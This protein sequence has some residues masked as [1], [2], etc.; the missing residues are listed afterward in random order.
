MVTPRYA[1]SQM[2]PALHKRSSCHR[3]V[4]KRGARLAPCYCSQILPVKDM[5]GKTCNLEYWEAERY[6]LMAERYP[7][8]KV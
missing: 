1:E 7:E 8:E 2:L 6:I 5:S 4:Q 3:F